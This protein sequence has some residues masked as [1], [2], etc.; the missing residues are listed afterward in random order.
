MNTHDNV[1]L[2]LEVLRRQVLSR[3]PRTH[4]GSLLIFESLIEAWSAEQRV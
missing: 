3:I 2:F 1:W 4:S